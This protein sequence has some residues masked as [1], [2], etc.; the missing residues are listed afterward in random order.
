[1]AQWDLFFSFLHLSIWKMP[2]RIFYF[3]MGTIRLVVFCG[4]VYGEGGASISDI[5]GHGMGMAGGMGLGLMGYYPL[6]ASHL[7]SLV[8][9]FWTLFS[10]SSRFYI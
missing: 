1:M 9:F 8:F 3:S 10:I 4:G 7:W 2:H 5:Q 6:S